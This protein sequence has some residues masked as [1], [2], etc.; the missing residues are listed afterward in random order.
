MTDMYSKNEQSV[1]WYALRVTGGDMD[2]FIDAMSSRGAECYYN[3]GAFRD[4]CFVRSTRSEIESV[5][6]AF[7]RGQ[8][9]H[10]LWDGLSFRPATVPDKRMR[11]FIRVAESGDGAQVYLDN[12]STLLKDCDK[13]RVTSGEYSGIEGRLVRIRKTKRVM[14]S[15]PCD[16]AVATGYVRPECMEKII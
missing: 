6:S 12:V 5:K 14:V 7:G 9:V 3:A 13:V 8:S 11:D 15:L 4:I 2:G 1:E 16:I 10:Y